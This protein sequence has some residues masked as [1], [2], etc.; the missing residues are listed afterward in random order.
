MGV[1][2]EQIPLL[3][4]HTTC[5]K[6]SMKNKMG[7]IALRD[8][9]M[10]RT[11]TYTL[12]ECRPNTLMGSC[13]SDTWGRGLITGQGPLGIRYIRK[14]NSFDVRPRASGYWWLPWCLTLSQRP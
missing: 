7:C 8:R 14:Q 13:G 11:V 5:S 2:R 1:S 4:Q 3:H 6:H 12:S 10:R 9:Y